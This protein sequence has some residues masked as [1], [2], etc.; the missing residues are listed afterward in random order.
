ML[1]HNW[2]A[3]RSCPLKDRRTPFSQVF[4]L[5]SL[6]RLRLFILANEL[7]SQTQDDWFKKYRDRLVTMLIVNTQGKKTIDHVN[8]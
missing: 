1:H 6:Q 5:T 4:L 3:V 7:C 8:R 2:L